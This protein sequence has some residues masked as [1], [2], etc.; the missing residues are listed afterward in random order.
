MKMITTGEIK[1]SVLVDKND[2]VKALRAVHKAFD[3]DKP[4]PGSGMPIPALA[5]QRRLQVAS[6]RTEAR[7]GVAPSTGEHG[8]HRR[9]RCHPRS[10]SRPHHDLQ[11][12][13]PPRQLLA[14]SRRSP[15]PASS[16]DMILGN[17][18]EDG[19]A[20]LSFSVPM[21]DLQRGLRD[22]SRRPAIDTE[23]IAAAD[24]NIARLDRQRHRHALAT[25]ASPA[26]CSAA[27]ASAASTSR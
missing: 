23:A 26:A 4:R 1:I 17:P 8:R 11:P 5:A 12:A 22:A 24:P 20:N 21:K 25:P 14:S 19:L 3:L 9:Q 16:S 27:L 7:T 6:G 2:G 15:A 10:R 18:A 13:R